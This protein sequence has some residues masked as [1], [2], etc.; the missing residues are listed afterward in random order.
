[1]TSLA[2]DS[3]DRFISSDSLLLS[4]CPSFLGPSVHSFIA[5]GQTDRPNDCKTKRNY[6]GSGR[7][8]TY[9]CT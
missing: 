1:M 9:T 2:L 4:V 5:N 3:A 6:K 8:N 7:K